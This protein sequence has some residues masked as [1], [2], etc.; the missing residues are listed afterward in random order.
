MRKIYSSIINIVKKA[1]K[2]NGKLYLGKSENT[3]NRIQS[4]GESLEQFFKLSFFNFDKDK[5][6]EEKNNIFS[7]IGNKNNPPDLMIKGGEAIEIKKISSPLSDLALNSSYPKAKL[8]NTDPMITKECKNAESWQE[9]N[10]IYTIGYVKEEKIKN[11]KKQYLSYI[12]LIDGPCYC[13]KNNLYENIKQ[14]LKNGINNIP[15]LDFEE[16]NELGKIKRVDPLGIT[17]LRI[18]GMWHI[19]NPLKFFTK[20]EYEIEE[21]KKIDIKNNSFNLFYITI[22]DLDK[23][24]K[25]ELENANINYKQIKIPNPNN[26]TDDL[27]AYLITY[28]KG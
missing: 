10:F 14:R 6:K 1:E 22:H 24:E 4:V 11:K 2:T 23:S 16:T 17:T 27:N 25:N 13:A 18:R 15:Y 19:E 28:F 12:F 8:F 20:S 26:P 3:S 5:F 9:K 21:I 7:Y